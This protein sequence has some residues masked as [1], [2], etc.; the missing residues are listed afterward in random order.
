MKYKKIFVGIIISTLLLSLIG[1]SDI[2]KI[3]KMEPNQV[4]FF[5]DNMAVF[6]NAVNVFSENADLLCIT[7]DKSYISNRDGETKKINELYIKSKKLYDKKNYDEI[8]DQILPIF[9]DC[10]LVVITEVEDYI[11]FTYATTLGEGIG[12]IYSKNG[13]EPS[14][15]DFYVTKTTK[16]N[17]NW[18]ACIWY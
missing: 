18:Y 9:R 8:Y 16:I 15:K 17:D 2:I 1:C 4:E 3:D 5:N 14:K 10:K 6:Q 12:W 7:P 13:V 11:K